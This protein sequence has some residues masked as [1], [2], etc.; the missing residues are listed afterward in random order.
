M[1][2]GGYECDSIEFGNF[3]LDGGAMFGVVPKILWERKI[4]ADE[5]NFIP[6]KA[7]S[8]LIRGNGKNILV[9]TG[10][11]RKLSE[12]MKKQYGID[13]F[14]TDANEALSKYGLSCDDITDIIITHLHFDHAGGST[15]IENGNAVP[16]FK[17][18]KYY[19]QKSQFEA[20]INP[21][22][23]ETSNYAKED[24]MPLE[25]SGVL[26][27]LSGGPMFSEGIEIIVTN[28]HTTGQQHTLITG[29][30][31]SLFF[32]ADLIPT[33]AHILL[34]W[35]AAYD[36]YP[37]TIMKEKEE[38]LSRAIKDNWILFFE[39]DPFI[40][41]ATIR[42]GSKSMEVDKICFI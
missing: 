15:I 6:M 2:F 23:G 38:I 28:G 42:Q 18:A 37:L 16:A 25:E 14:S 9:D 32:C 36:N 1:K 39:H 11:G 5:K 20:A 29:E 21:G 17:N 40:A 33:S 8:L 12:K 22:P 34:S 30:S 26:K 3:F 4:Q 41:A 27:M 35:R 10:P 7:R 31:A 13:D 19:L 24:F